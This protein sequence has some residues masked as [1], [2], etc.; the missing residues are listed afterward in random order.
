MAVY[1]LV[2]IQTGYDVTGSYYNALFSTT[3]GTLSSQLSRCSYAQISPTNTASFN[4][5]CGVG[6]IL[7]GEPVFTVETLPT[8]VNCRK[9]KAKAD[10]QVYTPSYTMIS[11]NS[12]TNEANWSIQI[13]SPNYD[14]ITYSYLAY[15]FQCRKSVYK[16]GTLLIP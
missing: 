11:T 4:L 15:N 3:I 1:E 5:K 7:V 13:S 14:G 2:C 9:E 8:I 12:S 6:E 10:Q 16:L